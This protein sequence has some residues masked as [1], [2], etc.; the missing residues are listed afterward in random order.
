MQDVWKDWRTTGGG[1]ESWAV[2]TT[3]QENCAITG[4]RGSGSN[5]S[6]YKKLLRVHSDIIITSTEGY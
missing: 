1:S 5:H 2:D 4:N 3:G 6:N